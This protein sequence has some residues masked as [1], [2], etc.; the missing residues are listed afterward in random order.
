[1]DPLFLVIIAKLSIYGLSPRKGLQ[2]LN[3]AMCI[4]DPLFNDHLMN[5]TQKLNETVIP[6][7]WKTCRQLISG[8]PKTP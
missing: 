3:V 4:V 5:S 1:M 6:Q 7:N 2:V 8:N